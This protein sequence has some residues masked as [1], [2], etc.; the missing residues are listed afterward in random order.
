[1]KTRDLAFVLI[2]VL[3]LYVLIQGVGRLVRL[4]E[5]LFPY[6]TDDGFADTFNVGLL[7]LFSAGSGIML[8]AVAALL[9]VK[10][11]KAASLAAPANREG[12]E[13][14]PLPR[15]PFS[16]V[17]ALGLTLVGVVVLVETLPS[18]LGQIVQLIQ[19]STSEYPSAF[20][21][22][23]WDAWIQLSADAIK[24]AL[25]AVLVLRPHGMYGAIRKLRELGFRRS[26]GESK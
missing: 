24:L 23:T 9:W 15:F 2:R 14:E 12:S 18:L 5:I 26:E 10:S 11:D 21:K 16:E 8:L 20:E 1:M 22:N 7:V 6:F 19:Y 25:A 17:Y 4:I 3:A 13:G